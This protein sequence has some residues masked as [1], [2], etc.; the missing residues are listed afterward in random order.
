MLYIV[1][2]TDARL[3]LHQCTFE[4]KMKIIY[5]DMERFLSGFDIPA[6]ASQNISGWDSDEGTNYQKILLMFP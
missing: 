5:L 1:F 3:S 6:S 2:E 4:N